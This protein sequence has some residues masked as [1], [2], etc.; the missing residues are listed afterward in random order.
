MMDKLP[1]IIN[2]KKLLV[3][4]QTKCSLLKSSLCAEVKYSFKPH[5]WFSRIIFLDKTSFRNY[6]FFLFSFSSE[7]FIQAKHEA[8]LKVT[9]EQGTCFKHYNKAVNSGQLFIYKS[10]CCFSIRTCFTRFTINI[11][12][13]R[14]SWKPVLNIFSFSSNLREKLVLIHFTT[15]IV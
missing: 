8:C 10:T 11:Q 7:T 12:N 3:G 4:K 14:L 15:T 2:F 1:I 9:S 6:F 13:N 5:Y